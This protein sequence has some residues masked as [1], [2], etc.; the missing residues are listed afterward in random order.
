MASL[1]DQAWAEAQRLIDPGREEVVVVLPVK[2]PR[3]NQIIPGDILEKFNQAWDQM[4]A[5]VVI[6]G[7]N[8]EYAWGT[9]LPDAMNVDVTVEN[10]GF[11]RIG[12]SGYPGGYVARLAQP[13]FGN[14]L[15]H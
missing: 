11:A 7:Q 2:R 12:W 13:K 10:R 4:V 8:A 15:P 3:P 5:K 14:S 9:I 6:V 1:L